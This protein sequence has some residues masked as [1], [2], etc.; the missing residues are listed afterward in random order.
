MNFRAL[1]NRIRLAAALQ[2]ALSGALKD[3]TLEGLAHSVG[4]RQ[5]TTFYAAFRAV[6][7]RTPQEIF[8]H[9]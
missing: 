8:S 3:L 4:F 9:T 6:A 7:G 1:L 5:R 2:A